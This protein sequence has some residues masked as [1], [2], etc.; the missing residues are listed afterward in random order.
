MRAVEPRQDQM[1]E[2]LAVASEVRPLVMT[3]LL[4]YRDGAVLV[5]SPSRQHF[6]DI[7]TSE[8][9]ITVAVH[10]TAALDDSRLI[11]TQQALPSVSGA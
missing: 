6:I 7:T 1:D 10:R 2:L 9:Y 5:E 8:E 3:N 4:R 11:A